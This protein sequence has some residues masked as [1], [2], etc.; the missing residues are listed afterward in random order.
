MYPILAG[1]RAL[2]EEKP[3]GMYEW[4][5][6]LSPEVLLQGDLGHNLA[7]A[8]GRKALEDQNPSKTGKSVSVW[9][10]CYLLAQNAYL[11]V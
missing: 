9:S 5:K 10:E 7:A 11:K 4:G 2:L 6:G 3:D 1:F 8:V